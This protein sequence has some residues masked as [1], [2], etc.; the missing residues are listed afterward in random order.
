MDASSLFGI[1]VPYVSD[2][3]KVETG[4]A[5]SSIEFASNKLVL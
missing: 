1:D 5:I 2:F 3:I 4:G